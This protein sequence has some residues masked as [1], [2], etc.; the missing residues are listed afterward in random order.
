MQS[1]A[2]RQT[3]VA[4]LVALAAAVVARAIPSSEPVVDEVAAFVQTIAR[5]GDLVVIASR[6]RQFALGAFGDLPVVAV[7]RM[8]LEVSRFDRVLVVRPPD[9]AAPVA[10]VSATTGRTLLSHTVADWEIDVIEVADREYVVTDLVGTFER[11]TA[12]VDYDAEGSADI[13]CDLH[14][15]SF[16]CGLASWNNVDLK[17]ENFAGQPQVC[18]WTHPVDEATMIVEFPWIEGATHLSGWFGITD[19]G[20]SIRD[21]ARVTLTT[22]AGDTPERVGVQNT[23]GRRPFEHEL[24]AGYSGPIRFEVTAPRAGVRHFCWDIQAVRRERG[25]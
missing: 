24:P 21:G 8:P 19:Y 20:A 12:T 15:G 9:A 14:D 11:A 3:L 16:D 1:V 7:D 13:F 6:E 22:F 5:D 23:K 10:R 4:L 25:T 17:V 18:V 2:L